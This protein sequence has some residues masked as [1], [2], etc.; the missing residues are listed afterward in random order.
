MAGHIE[1]LQK[2]E[3]L[4]NGSVSVRRTEKSQH[5]NKVRLNNL[6]DFEHFNISDNGQ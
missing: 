5:L 4:V 6:A 1:T 3:K 2:T